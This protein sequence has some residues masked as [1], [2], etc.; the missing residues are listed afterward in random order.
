MYKYL[1][2]NLQLIYITITYYKAR[3]MKLEAFFSTT[4]RHILLHKHF[5]PCLHELL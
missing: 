3:G 4:E 1:Y 2:N 5:L